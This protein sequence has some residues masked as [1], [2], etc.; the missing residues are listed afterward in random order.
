[1]IVTEL[2]ASAYLANQL[3]PAS[4]PA[5][6]W[7]MVSALVASL[8]VI[9]AIL[10]YSRV[11]KLT[12]LTSSAKMVM[13]LNKEFNSTEMRQYRRELASVLLAGRSPNL[14]DNC[15][16]LE[17]FEE[18]GYMTR[19]KILDGGMVWN[20][21]SWWIEPYF[22]LCKAA[23]TDARSE[24]QSPMFF[25]ETQWLYEYLSKLQQKYEKRP[26]IPRS[27]D[28]CRKFLEG[29]RDLTLRVHDVHLGAQG[30]TNE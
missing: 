21:F 28:A 15:P 4:E 17:F 5:P 13:D 1:L 19:R 8:G 20:T 16:V 12:R 9:A 3:A 26:Y 23:I 29:E 18:I 27:N 2:I 25:Y 7:P 22:L 10:Y 30:L 11:L 6:P 24:T 14:V